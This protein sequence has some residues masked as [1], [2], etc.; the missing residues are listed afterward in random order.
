M[1]HT[2]DADLLIIM[3]TSLTVQPFASLADMVNDD[4]P[5]VLINIDHVGNIGSKPDD[6]VLLGKCDD[7]IRELC[8]EL[9]WEEDLDRLWN[10]TSE[11]VIADSLDASA[12]DNNDSTSTTSVASAKDSGTDA[13][14]SDAMKK[15]EEELAKLDLEIEGA[16]IEERLAQHEEDIEEE[17]RAKNKEISEESTKGSKKAEDK[18]PSIELAATARPAVVSGKTDEEQRETQT[19]ETKKQE[20]KLTNGKF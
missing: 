16:A 10:E 5:R 17:E 20:V 13:S 1:S 9:G 6:V 3:G 4:C 8:K 19:V 11:S 2:R 15:I 12:T 18:P 14:K 7:I